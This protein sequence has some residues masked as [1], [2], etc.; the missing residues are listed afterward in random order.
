MGTPL[1][2]DIVRTARRLLRLGQDILAPSAS[3]AAALV[4]D[5]GA[6][7]DRLRDVLQ[8]PQLSRSLGIRGGLNFFLHERAVERDPAAPFGLTDVASGDI[9]LA[10]IS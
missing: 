7:R 8:N 1:Q 9:V 2:D 6:G 4:P 5:C 3:P 10:K